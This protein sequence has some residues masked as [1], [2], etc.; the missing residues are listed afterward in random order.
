MPLTYEQ[1]WHAKSL[2]N[3]AAIPL[4][5][6]VNFQSVP[7]PISAAPCL[8][9]KQAQMP[10][11]LLHYYA[12]AEPD[13]PQRTWQ[14]QNL[15]VFGTDGSGNPICMRRDN[16]T[17]VLVDHEDLSI[18]EQFINSSVA[19]LSDSLLAFFGEKD[20]SN[21]RTAM[22]SIDLPALAK[23][24]FWRQE[25]DALEYEQQNPHSTATKSTLLLLTLLRR[26]DWRL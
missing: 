26:L 16:G 13:Y 14:F 3:S 25:S 1:L 17:V 10:Q 4:S 19:Q 12:H 2:A 6:I 24:C 9:F 20:A 11:D 8:D 23:N 15:L 22:K 5:Q 21:F 7:I 18:P